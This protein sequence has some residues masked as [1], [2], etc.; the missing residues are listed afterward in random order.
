MDP[1]TILKK[2][3]KG[4]EEIRTRKYGI[5]QPLRQIL[6]FVDGKAMASKIIEKAAGLP[7]VSRSLDELTRQGFIRADETVTAA[8]VKQ[9]LIA[10][11]RDML[12][13]DAEKVVSKIT[14]APETKEGLEA[15]TAAC[16]KLVRIT[17]D[18]K[19]A[20]ELMSRCSAIMS[21]L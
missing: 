1:K 2:T 3:D 7:D 14:D 8:M 16:K 5:S 13:A 17:I 20:E 6:I 15:V 21:R 12:G 18:E 9:D 11:A 10:M 19:K 4:E